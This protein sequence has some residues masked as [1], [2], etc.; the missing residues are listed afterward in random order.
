MQIPI[1]KS[2]GFS[3]DTHDL[4]CVDFNKEMDDISTKFHKFALIAVAGDLDP[5][6]H[7]RGQLQRVKDSCAA[8]RAHYPGLNS[9]AGKGWNQPFWNLHGGRHGGR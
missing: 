1:F 3:I 9:A 4:H 5:V 2:I 8:V 7:Q 6:L